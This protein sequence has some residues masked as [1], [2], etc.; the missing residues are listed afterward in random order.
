V[1]TTDVLRESAL[2]HILRACLQLEPL[3]PL[4]AERFQTLLD[5]AKAS[6]TPMA[7]KVEELF[8]S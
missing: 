8:E 6:F 1:F 7:R 4:T 3:R 5:G 2:E